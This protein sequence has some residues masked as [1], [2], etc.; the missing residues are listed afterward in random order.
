MKDWR[1]LL[2]D[3]RG[4]LLALGLFVLMFAI[5]VT[6]HPAGFTPNVVQT[7]ANKGVILALVAMA[8]TFVVLT[9]G[10]DLSVGMVFILCNCLASYLLAGSAIEITL[11][12]IGVL[13]AGAACG[14]LNGLIVIF[15][16]LQPIVTTIATG[17]IFF[18]IAL[19][20]RPYPG[21]TPD[22][23]AD[24]ADAFT[25][26]LF[27]T[28]PTS[29]VFLVGVI[30]VIWVPFRRSLIGRTVY[31]VGS[32]DQAA[33]MSGLPVRLGR[34]SAFVLSGLLASLGGIFLTFITYSGEASLANGDNY[35]LFSIASVVLGGVS[36]YGGRG[37][38]VGAVF[39]ALAFRA[40]G[41]LLFVFDLDPLWQPLFQGIVLALAVT[42]GAARLFRVRNR[43]EL[44][45]G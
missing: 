38:A 3:Q 12:L 16:R 40:I 42:L 23:A 5:Y 37:S 39:G 20:L 4:T 29:L 21:T 34:F 35:T 31:A 18:G 11:G 15:G 43:L 22:F 26:K 8:Q 30:L 17:A 7:A 6:N 32:S 14:A 24:L 25:G 28:I 41:D 13:A 45:G 27:N 2:A 36:L 1:Y 10:I 33:Y 44:F 9:A 19:W